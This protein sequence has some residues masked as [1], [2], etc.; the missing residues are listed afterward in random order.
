MYYIRKLLLA[1]VGLLLFTGSMLASIYIGH[2][3]SL[4]S[5]TFEMEQ[6]MYHDLSDDV[7]FRSTVIYA[8]A[9]TVSAIIGNLGGLLS[10][11]MFASA[12]SIASVR[13]I[14]REATSSRL[15]MVLTFI[16]I[17]FVATS[18]VFAAAFFHVMARST[19]SLVCIGMGSVL[20]TCFGTVLHLKENHRKPVGDPK[21]SDVAAKAPIDLGAESIIDTKTQ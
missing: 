16:V 19:V 12:L 14:F 11:L 18:E 21:G 4:A 6:K 20:L 1:M 7:R 3:I 5:G 10:G 17:G 9:A 8:V 13:D 15:E 2:L